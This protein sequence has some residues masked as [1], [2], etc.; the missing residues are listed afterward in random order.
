M[1]I[2]IPIAFYSFPILLEWPGFSQY[3]K[4]RIPTELNFETRLSFFSHLAGFVSLYFTLVIVLTF[5]TRVM[6]GKTNPVAETDHNITITLNR[7]LSNSV[8]QT[9][10]FLPLL[11]NFILNRA[12]SENIQLGLN[13]TFIWI[14]GRILFLIGYVLGV[15]INLSTMR[16]GGFA[17]TILPACYL[18]VDFVK[19]L[20]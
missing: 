12:T 10:V 16:S 11:M 9:I 6:L 7:I 4:I 2:L 5:M 18:I 13:L 1:I 20:I 19:A 3:L 15:V 14:L 8:E 17:L